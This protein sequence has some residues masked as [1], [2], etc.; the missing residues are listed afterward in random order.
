MD[1][2]GTFSSCGGYWLLKAV[3]KVLEGFVVPLAMS[4]ILSYV[5]PGQYASSPMS[6]R[7][8]PPSFWNSN[9]QVPSS[10]SSSSSSRPPSLAGH[11][12]ASPA[13]LYDPYHAGLHPLQ[14]PA[15]DPWA[16][17]SLS[18]QAYGHR[19]MAHDVYQAAMSSVPSSSRPYHQ[20]SS[21]SLQ[22]HLA[23]IPGVT[24]VGSQMGMAKPESWGARYHDAFTSPDFSHGLDTNYSAPHYPNVPGLETGVPQEGAKDLYWF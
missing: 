11:L 16:A 10:S 20:Y 4:D 13:E 24:A 15:P 3:S 1:V 8:F 21:L 18:S 19:S 14:P 6:S 23:R 12:G 17:Y 9:Y 5:D 22:P 2:A 7:N